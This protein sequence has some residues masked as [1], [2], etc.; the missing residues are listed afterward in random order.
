MIRRQKREI[1]RPSKA[2]EE[3]HVDKPY[4]GKANNFMESFSKA[5]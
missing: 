5:T 1:T 2:D 3:R 4:D